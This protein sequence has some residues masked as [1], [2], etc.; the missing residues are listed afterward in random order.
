MNERIKSV[1]KAVGL[2]QSKMGEAMN[3]NQTTVA[4]W[5]SGTRV[6]TKPTF[7]LFCMKFSVNREWLETG[8]GEMFV[9]RTRNEELALWIGEVMNS[10][11][12]SIKIRLLS[13]LSK[14]PPEG[15]ELIDKFAADLADR[16]GK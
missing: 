9:Q 8:E 12:D 4:M 14:L 5:E 15:W 11:P 2:T 16:E 6:M 1:R 3:V 7:E 13:A 10:Q